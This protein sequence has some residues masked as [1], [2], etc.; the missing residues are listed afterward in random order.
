MGS[1]SKAI[2]KASFI[3]LFCNYSN[4]KSGIYLYWAN[5]LMEDNIEVEENSQDALKA[6]GNE[7]FKQ[8]NYTK[9]IEYYQEAIS[10]YLQLS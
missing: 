2:S 1:A 4:F 3:Y 7:E 10:N 9:A 5:L 6:L 8:H